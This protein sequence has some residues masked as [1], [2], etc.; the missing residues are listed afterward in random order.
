MKSLEFKNVNTA[1]K[2]FTVNPLS[3]LSYF[4]VNIKD[5]L[6]RTPTKSIQDD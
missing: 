4:T 6:G 1:K 2:T 3:T 5:S